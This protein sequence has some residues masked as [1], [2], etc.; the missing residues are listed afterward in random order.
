MVKI[1]FDITVMNVPFVR[2]VEVLG[3]VLNKTLL[4]ALLSTS[5]DGVLW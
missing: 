2:L 3:T 1:I 5:S 4:S